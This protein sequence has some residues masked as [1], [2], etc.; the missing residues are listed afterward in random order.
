[1]CTLPPVPSLPLAQGS[2]LRS[3]QFATTIEPSD[4]KTTLLR[5]DAL[6]I[7][8]VN[9]SEIAAVVAVAFESNVH[10]FKLSFDGLKWRL[11]SH[12]PSLFSRGLLLLR[13]AGQAEEPTRA[14]LKH[15]G[16]VP[17]LTSDGGMLSL[18]RIDATHFAI[19]AGD[20]SVAGVIY[21]LGRLQSFRQRLFIPPPC[22]QRDF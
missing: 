19:V 14:I 16:Q 21:T 18:A 12:S 1:V 6:R 13:L 2:Q 17:H 22:R 4:F 9:S 8:S 11:P 7:E 20:V 5:A 3:E 15:D 10:V